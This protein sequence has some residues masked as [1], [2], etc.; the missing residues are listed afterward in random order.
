MF[1]SGLPAVSGRGRIVGWEQR[2]QRLLVADRLEGGTLS[3]VPRA[4]DR[5]PASRNSK[6]GRPA[7]AIRSTP[8]STCGVSI[9]KL[10]QRHQR[11]RVRRLVAPLRAIIRAPVH[12][13]RLVR[14]VVQHARVAAKA[15]ANFLRLQQAP[16]PSRFL[17]ALVSEPVTMATREQLWR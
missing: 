14:E 7:I 10:R 1:I 11:L 16:L 6:H 3:D 4:G 13:P 12:P 2:A 15:F 17:L 5:R 9:Y 8:R